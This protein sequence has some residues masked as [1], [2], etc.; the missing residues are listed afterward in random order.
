MY[1]SGNIKYFK[2]N[3]HIQA[4]KEKYTFETGKEFTS[5]DPEE[6]QHLIDDL[7]DAF[8]DTGVGAWSNKK[9]RDQDI[10]PKLKA[11]ISVQPQTA[12]VIHEPSLKSATNP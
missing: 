11:C 6:I 4:L 2:I 7:E 9:E 10:K 8:A 3:R 1:N 12:C 5:T